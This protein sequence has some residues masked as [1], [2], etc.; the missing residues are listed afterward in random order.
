MN[1]LDLYYPEPKD[2]QLTLSF[3][4]PKVRIAKT[5]ARS[6]PQHCTHPLSWVYVVGVGPKSL[7]TIKRIL[8]HHWELNHRYLHHRWPCY[9]LCYH[10][11]ELLFMRHSREW[12]TTWKVSCRQRDSGVSGQNVNQSDAS[13][14]TRTIWA[15]KPQNKKSNTKSHVTYKYNCGS[16][17]SNTIQ[18]HGT[19]LWHSADMVIGWHGHMCIEELIVGR[20]FCSEYSQITYCDK[21]VVKWSPSCSGH[22]NIDKVERKHL[23]VIESG[24][25]T[26]SNSTANI[27]PFP[28]HPTKHSTSG[29]H[30]VNCQYYM[31]HPTD[32]D[33]HIPQTISWTY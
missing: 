33:T 23:A 17:V 8:V 9:Q 14:A 13:P 4:L 11:Q 19:M 22:L 16:Q 21:S 3:L 25:I 12:W 5:T 29:W 10:K 24:N 1:C 28:E 32:G 26:V 30:L 2:R 18:W 27:M 15:I 6:P 31:H 20:L 7:A